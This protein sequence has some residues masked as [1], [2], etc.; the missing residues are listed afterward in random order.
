MNYKIKDD[1]I[2]EFINKEKLKQKLNNIEIYDVFCSCA[3]KIIIKLYSKLTIDLS[4]LNY[5]KNFIISNGLDIFYN[6]FF[7]LINYTNN[8]KVTLFLI[9]RAIILYIEFITISNNRILAKDFYYNPKISDAVVF[10]YKKTLG[11]LNISSLKKTNNN[12]YIVKKT[13]KIILILLYETYIYNN[14]LEDDN[15]VMNGIL[16]HFKDLFYKL[17][18]NTNNNLKIINLINDKIVSFINHEIYS[19]NSINY[20]FYNTIYSLKIICNHLILTLRRYKTNQISN[21]FF[22]DIFEK[23]EKFI[24]SNHD[25]SNYTKLDLLC[26]KYKKYKLNTI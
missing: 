20:N 15:I 18:N 17:F 24:K 7:I 8:I 21:D 9:Q 11:D 13:C 16:F 14:S 4:E 26:K 22:I 6:I 25:I 3:K 19:N 12:F 10:V 23:Y 1:D 2:L 5:S